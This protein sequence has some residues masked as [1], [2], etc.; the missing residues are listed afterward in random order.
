MTPPQQPPYASPAPVTFGPPE[1]L[2]RPT[3]VA[4][5]FGVS[6]S[7]VRAWVSAGKLTCTRTPGGQRRYRAAEVYALRNTPHT[8]PAPRAD[9]GGGLSPPG[10]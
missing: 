9:E 3:E 6:V 10:D 2:L 8:L 5:L 4:I 7:T 1:L